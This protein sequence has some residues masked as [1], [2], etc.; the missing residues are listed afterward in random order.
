MADSRQ[1]RIQAKIKELTDQ[2]VPVQEAVIQAIRQAGRSK[3]E[4]KK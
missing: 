1:D 2:G 3:K 4:K